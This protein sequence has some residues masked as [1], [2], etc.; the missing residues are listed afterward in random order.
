[1][2]G[3]L[4]KRGD[5][6]FTTVEIIIVVLIACL[7]CTATIPIVSHFKSASSQAQ[8]DAKARSIYDA[9]Q[10]RALYMRSA[11]SLAEVHS[12]VAQDGALAGQVST[13]PQ[14]WVAGRC[15]YPWTELSYMEGGVESAKATMTLLSNSA[16]STTEMTEGYY[17]IEADLQTGD[18]YGVFYSESPFSYDDIVAL[19]NRADAPAAAGMGYYG[20]VDV[21]THTLSESFAPTVSI[22][23]G[24][25]LVA[26]ISC[27]GFR[28]Y[29]DST[30]G[31]A[32]INV[33]VTDEHGG[34]CSAN[35]VIPIDA[36]TPDTITAKVTLDSMQSGK[37]FAELFSGQGDFT[38]SGLQAG[39]DITVTATVSYASFH[40]SNLEE[41]TTPSAGAMANSLFESKGSGCI[42]IGC[43]RHLDNLRSERYPVQLDSSV[44]IV[45]TA[46]IDFSAT[47][48]TSATSPQELFATTGFEP[49]VNST[50]FGDD[51]NVGKASFDGGGHLISGCNV[52]AGSQTT[53]LFAFANGISICNVILV[54]T[55]VTGSDATGAL[56]G[57]MHGGL[58]D[59]CGVRLS[60][61]LS[62]GT[63]RI[64]M[65]AREAV[66]RVQASSGSSCVGGLVGCV[67][68]HA[69]IEGSYAACDV[70]ATSGFIQAA[71]GL[72]GS[73]SDSIVQDSYASGSIT[74]ASRDAGGL[75]GLQANS[76]LRNCISVGDVSAIQASGGMLGTVSGG[77]VSQCISYGHVCDL[78][79]QESITLGAFSAPAASAAFSDCAYLR[80]DAYNSLYAQDAT[81]GV[82]ARSYRDL[83][84]SG[85]GTVSKENTHSYD[86]AL[87]S[88]RFPFACTGEEY[89]GDWPGENL[90]SLGALAYYEKYEDGSTGYYMDIALTSDGNVVRS[91]I[92]NTLKDAVVTEDGYA[93]VE[94]YALKQASYRLNDG[95]E[96]TLSLSGDTTSSQ[97]LVLIDDSLEVLTG[98]GVSLDS[99]QVYRLPPVLQGIDSEKR[100]S[101]Y[102]K[103]VFT[104]SSEHT[105]DLQETYY[106]NPELAK[107]ATGPS[108]GTTLSSSTKVP[109]TVPKTV[110]VRS[111]RQLNALGRDMYWCSPHAGSGSEQFTFTQE[112][113]IDF[114]AYTT[115]YCGRDLDLTD[116]SADNSY[117]NVPIGTSGND[118]NL[119]FSNV[120]DGQMHRIVDF[121][122]ET[123]TQQAA[124]LFGTISGGS[125]KNVLLCAS[126]AG[127]SYVRSSYVEPK[128]S[129]HSTPVVGSLVGCV[130]A[131]AASTAQVKNCAMS[132]M[133]VNWCSPDDDY[134][135]NAAAGGLVGYNYGEINDCSAVADEV[136]IGSA[137]IGSNG[138]IRVMDS[139]G[140]LVGS[141]AGTVK[142]CYAGGSLAYR[143]S[144]SKAQV[145]M[146]GLCGH[147]FYY[148]TTGKQQ[149]IAKVSD[150]YSY[151]TGRVYADMDSHGIANYYQVASDAVDNAGGTNLSSTNSYRLDGYDILGCSFQMY[152]YQDP[153]LVYHS[154]DAS[155][156]S[157]TELA[158]L[159]LSQDSGRADA[160]H[161]YATFSDE[162]APRSAYPYPAVVRTLDGYYV[163]YGNWPAG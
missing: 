43:A 99:L 110:S 156:K 13:Q 95:D 118:V 152:S 53:G 21:D 142:S 48:T 124:G 114:S 29:M 134:E 87:A 136:S 12:D 4:C 35:R 157:A 18:V 88:A 132:G 58:I 41:Y 69:T 28:K 74:S 148:S 155:A 70:T 32:T 63:R 94:P 15:D 147:Y 78:S 90:S 38:G 121:R 22:E 85:S 150:C 54:D 146:G 50:L 77:A 89:W 161:S 86:A 9:A 120:Y 23:N 149:S 104:T 141:N 93:L 143:A 112:C 153:L 137:D 145:E 101:F 125:V 113:D 17:L 10:S 66:Y 81:E 60:N 139:L 133:Q 135:Y 37:S 24:N 115:T 105:D 106:Y 1:M 16:L 52:S 80:Q 107:T 55:R 30:D 56:V 3:G 160:T 5:K 159:S 39:D 73:L 59:G 40:N 100:K 83:S 72:V 76:S 26:D 163:H 57:R 140:G 62:D 75:V 109:D 116:T 46:D 27:T 127:S 64:D 82:Q 6:A 34:I 33:Q 47:D 31:T 122:L 25:E 119:A 84:E 61:A 123:S 7:V 98:S 49:I 2:M 20:G 79:G 68:G 162:S 117:R 111:A 42:C 14:D 97:D 96:N 45:Q 92:V 144:T 129:Y 91:D 158:D 138:N 44:R 131:D 151:A 130:Y 51:D 103:L 71:G 11:G 126:Y 128:E 108:Q 154:G 65:D 102:D 36:T 19:S 67:D 8:L